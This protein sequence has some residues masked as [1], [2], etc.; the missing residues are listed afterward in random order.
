MKNSIQFINH[1]SILIS[2]EK[3]SILTDPWYSGSSFDDGW[4]LLFQNKKI[5]IENILKKV[6]YIWISHEH[7]D[8]F[9]IK[10]LIDYEKIIKQKKI[11]FLFQKSK[12]QRVISYLKLKNFKCIELEDNK[13]F[14]IDKNFNVKVVKCDF[15]DSALIV[16]LDNKKIINL[17][18]CPLKTKSEILN[19]KKRHGEFDF[20]FTQFSYAAWKG[21]KNNLNWRKFAAAEKIQTLKYQSEILNSKFTIPFASF[22]KFCD[23][24]NFY[25]N[26]SIN[27]PESI[28][29]ECKNISSNILFLKPYQIL[30]LDNPKI[31]NKGYEFWNSIYNDKSNFNV[32][33]NIKKFNLETLQ[34][35]FDLYQKRIFTKNS[36]YLIKFLSKIKFLNFFQPIIIELRDLQINV[37][38]D[39]TNKIFEKVND[40]SDIE[41]NS[42]SLYL[43]F[44]QD[45]GFDTLTVNGCFE[46]KKKN[47]FSKMSKIFAIGSLNNLGF[48]LNTSIVFKI[49]LIYLF[50]KKLFYVKK[51]LE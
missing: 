7:P 47:S 28:I 33:K 35:A 11:T 2:N 42:K 39:L 15:Y 31:E 16:H 18:D 51:K 44:M 21:G 40:K 45:F 29:K 5:D 27:S 25:L 43:I 10:F 36:K 6:N 12:D 20:L 37:K 48:N 23:N 38:V 41:M 30:D 49:S 3:K 34:E 1:A 24:Y 13:T 17:N 8:H 4:E 9:S 46:E 14:L 32:N 26:D 50:L 22:I 19:F